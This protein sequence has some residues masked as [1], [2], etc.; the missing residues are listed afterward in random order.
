MQGVLIAFVIS[1]SLEGQD[2]N[3]CLCWTLPAQL[4]I[5]FAALSAL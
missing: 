2:I 5:L 3:I 1:F 4:R